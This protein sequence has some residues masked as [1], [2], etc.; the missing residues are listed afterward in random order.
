MMT[1]EEIVEDDGAKPKPR[2]IW[3]NEY[4]P[5]YARKSAYDSKE[6]A[7]RSATPDRISCRKFVEVDE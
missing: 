3:V 5:L 6:A 1:H 2:T 7:D 4:A